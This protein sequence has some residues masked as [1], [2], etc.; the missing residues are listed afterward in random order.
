MTLSGFLTLIA[1][2]LQREDINM[3]SHVLEK[4]QQALKGTRQ[5]VVFSFS[6][7]RAEAGA[8]AAVQQQQQLQRGTEE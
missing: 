2:F 1:V 5:H 6:L 8:C 7:A 4:S 3:T